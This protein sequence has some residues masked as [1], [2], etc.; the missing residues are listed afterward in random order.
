M[1]VRR[2]RVDAAAAIAVSAAFLLCGYE[3][4]RSVSSSLF[5]HAYGAKNLPIVMALGPVAN[6]SRSRTRSTA[7][8]GTWV[9][10]HWCRTRF[11]GGWRC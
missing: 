8:T 11:S 1:G 6:R 9:R 2:D 5:I 10:L 3:F 7:G 4:V